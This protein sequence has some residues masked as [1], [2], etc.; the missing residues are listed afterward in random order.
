VIGWLVVA[1]LTL[2]V[3]ALVGLALVSRVRS[4]MS[5]DTYRRT[6]QLATFTVYFGVWGA[7]VGGAFWI[8]A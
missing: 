2:A 7:I 3:V 4:R 5:F 1:F 8:A 6:V